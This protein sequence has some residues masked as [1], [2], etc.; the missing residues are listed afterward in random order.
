MMSPGRETGSW[1]GSASRVWVAAQRTIEPL[2]PSAMRAP[3][4]VWSW[5]PI[6]F[7][8]LAAAA[9]QPKSWREESLQPRVKPPENA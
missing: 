7:T 3:W 4:F 2:R 9:A 1:R 6:F 5:R 8:L